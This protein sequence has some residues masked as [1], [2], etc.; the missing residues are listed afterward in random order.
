MQ[1]AGR[2]RLPRIDLVLAVLRETVLVTQG[3][4][5]EAV[6]DGHLSADALP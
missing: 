3:A 1:S 2:S 5:E 4:A 6:K